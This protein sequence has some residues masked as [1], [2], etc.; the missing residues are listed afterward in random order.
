MIRGLN[1]ERTR[2]CPLAH[3]HVPVRFATRDLFIL[4]DERG[5]REK[6]EGPLEPLGKWRIPDLMT[7]ET[8]SSSTDG[9]NDFRTIAR[10]IASLATGTSFLIGRKEPIRDGSV[11]L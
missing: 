5:R 9:E 4:S 10:A 6:E 8:P 7:S 11:S 3:S 1:I 2:L